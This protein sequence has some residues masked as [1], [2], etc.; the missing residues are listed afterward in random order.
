MKAELEAARARAA[1]LRDP[2]VRAIAERA[3][4]AAARHDLRGVVEAFAD[5]DASAAA[6]ARELFGAVP[7]QGFEIEEAIE[8]APEELE[9]PELEL[10]PLDDEEAPP[11]LGLAL[12]VFE[13]E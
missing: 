7:E 12:V 6:P 10:R 4:L 9:N 11:D 1:R 8:L 2:V 3:L 5:L 13:E